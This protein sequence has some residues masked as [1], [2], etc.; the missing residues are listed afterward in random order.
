VVN[1]ALYLDM[2][3]YC[4]YDIDYVVCHNLY[5]KHDNF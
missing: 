4:N 1:T 3:F 5:Y 2:Y